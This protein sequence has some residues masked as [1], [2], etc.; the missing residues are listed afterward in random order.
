MLA[1]LP[2]MLYREIIAR[3]RSIRDGCAERIISDS[4]FYQEGRACVEGRLRNR[5]PAGWWPVHRRIRSPATAPVARNHRACPRRLC[6][7]ICSGRGHADTFLPPARRAS[8]TGF[9][10]HQHVEPLR[11]DPSPGT[12]RAE[13]RAEA[14]ATS[15]AQRSLASGSSCARPLAGYPYTRRHSSPAGHAIRRAHPAV[16]AKNDDSERL[17]DGHRRRLIARCMSTD[18][19]AEAT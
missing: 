14:Y 10:K 9:G 11:G 12:S 7:C 19:I 15:G 16:T 4:A 17:G 3:R 6:R 5:S 13:A 1:L 2:A 8:P 18:A